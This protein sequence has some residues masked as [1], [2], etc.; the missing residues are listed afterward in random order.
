MAQST[1]FQAPDLRDERILR[2]VAG[3]RPCRHGG[4]RLETETLGPKALIHNYGHGGCGITLSMGTAIAAADLLDQ[5]A[6]P[7]APVAVLGAGVVGLTTAR[8]LARRGRSVTVYAKK[9]GINTLSALAGALFLPVGI[10]TEHPD[11]GHNRFLKI[12]TDSKHA[13]DQL[14]PVK[15]GIQELPVYEP[16]FAADSEFLFTNGTIAPPTPLDHL[17]IPG[18]PRSGRTFQATFIHTL[19]FLNALIADLKTAGVQIHDRTF[20]DR[21]QIEQLPEP[22]IVNCMAL[23]SRE[24]FDDQAL[25]P[26]RGIL[27]HMEPQDLG[28]IIHDGYK[29]MFPRE[30]ALVLG[31]CFDE[32]VWDDVPDE[33]IAHEILT[34]HRRFFGLG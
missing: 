17:P 8:E 29:Y 18:P 21:S 19:R 10:E 4:L 34:H 33:R 9:S 5:H 12:L 13:L 3:I 2:I 15:Y 1:Q 24:L 22:A 11:I 6:E 27:V 25:Y 20:E 14:D 28:Y 26:A 31:G 23:G 7:D 30:D 16:A 32:G